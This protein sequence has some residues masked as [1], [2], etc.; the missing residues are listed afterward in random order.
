MAKS[1]PLSFDPASLKEEKGLPFICAKKIQYRQ[2]FS[3]TWVLTGSMPA[4]KWA[5]P[6]R[7][8]CPLAFETPCQLS[9]C[10]EGANFVA[11]CNFRRSL[12]S[13]ISDTTMPLAG[14]NFSIRKAATAFP[15]FF[16]T[17]TPFLVHQ[18]YYIGN[19]A[20]NIFL[21]YSFRSRSET[22]FIKISR[23]SSESHYRLGTWP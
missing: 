12:E 20:G 5:F 4:F 3:S 22:Q 8:Q 6:V 18:K 21:M 15:R 7:R 13:P 10:D 1:N 9:N 23:P 14:L 2:Q 19:L 16:L 17:P 11:G